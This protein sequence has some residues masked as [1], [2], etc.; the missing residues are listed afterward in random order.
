MSVIGKDKILS[1][2]LQGLGARA[3]IPLI[4]NPGSE[5]PVFP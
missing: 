4:P 5:I 1:Y 3:D 2:E